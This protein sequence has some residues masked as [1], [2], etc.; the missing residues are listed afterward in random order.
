MNDQELSLCHSMGRYFLTVESGAV[1]VRVKRF[2]DTRVTVAALIPSIP[3]SLLRHSFSS[4][5]MPKFWFSRPS[6]F[7][8][9][10]VAALLLFVS[11]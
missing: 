3:P 4:F 2:D 5:L 10:F 11:I 9:C 8:F 6:L 7:R 1:D